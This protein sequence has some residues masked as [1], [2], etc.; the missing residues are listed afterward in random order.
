MML[1]IQFLKFFDYTIIPPLDKLKAEMFYKGHSSYWGNTNQ[2]NE[3]VNFISDFNIKAACF[4]TD[5]INSTTFCARLLLG[6]IPRAHGKFEEKREFTSALMT[7]RDGGPF[8]DHVVW[9]KTQ[10][11]KLIFS[12]VPYMSKESI[13]KIFNDIAHDFDFPASV[14]IKTLPNEYHWRHTDEVNP[15][16]Y[17]IYDER[18]IQL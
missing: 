1:F 3:L 6:N 8:A 12:A 2:Y 7:I 11:D 5:C 13:L 18:A 9:W 15:P 10:N 4:G 16:H 17:I 14:K